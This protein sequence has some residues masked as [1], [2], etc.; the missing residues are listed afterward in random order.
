M[1]DSVNSNNKTVKKRRAPPAQFKGQIKELGNVLS[2]VSE[3]D[4]KQTES[5]DYKEFIEAKK[6]T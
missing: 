1:P 2:S 5:A 6:S 4:W 3:I